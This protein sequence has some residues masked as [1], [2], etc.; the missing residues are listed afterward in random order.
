MIKYLSS[1][2]N[3]FYIFHGICFNSNPDFYFYLYASDLISRMDTFLI[4]FEFPYAKTFLLIL[5]YAFVEWWSVEKFISYIYTYSS[6]LF[7]PDSI[8]AEVSHI[9][10]SREKKKWHKAYFAIYLS[11]NGKNYSDYLAV[12]FIFFSENLYLRCKIKYQNFTLLHFIVY[13]NLYFV[14]V[15]PSQ[16]I[17]I[18]IVKIS[19]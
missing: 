1:A 14:F 5:T 2:T 9:L 4:L 17:L 3:L 7:L 6:N 10:S 15:T 12:Q 11:L 13:F 18:A 16:C 8:W 19:Y